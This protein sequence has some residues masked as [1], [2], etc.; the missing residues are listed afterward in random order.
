MAE[1]LSQKKIYLIRH[2]QSKHNEA[3]NAWRATRGTTEDE[4]RFPDPLFFDAECAPQFFR[5]LQRPN[6]L[7]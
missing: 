3:E 2:G 1:S 7:V 6:S 4:E 5:S